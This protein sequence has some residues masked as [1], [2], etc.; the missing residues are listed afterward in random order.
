MTMGAKGAGSWVTVSEENPPGP[1]LGRGHGSEWPGQTPAASCRV[2]G[3]IT[4][5]IQEREIRCFHKKHLDTQ[6]FNSELPTRH[7]GL[8][9]ALTLIQKV[10]TWGGGGR[11]R[12][13]DWTCRR[14]RCCEKTICHRNP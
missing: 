9:T 6:R 8:G 4:S 13:G 12:R 11:W 7:M 14:P 2:L 10:G 1:P 3:E 5:R